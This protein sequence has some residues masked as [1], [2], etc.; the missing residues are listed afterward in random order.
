[1]MARRLCTRGLPGVIARTAGPALPQGYQPAQSSGG[2][3]P[4][5]DISQ[6]ISAAAAIQ[7]QPASEPSQN[8]GSS[9][10]ADV[11]SP[12]TGP[13]SEAHFGAAHSPLFE[14]IHNGG[15]SN[16]YA[17]KNGK[18]VDPS[19]YSSVWAGHANHVHVAAGPNTVVAL[20]K[21]AQQMGLK[22]G[23]NPYFTGHP[24][25]GGH[26]SNSY[27]YR[28]GKTKSGKVAGEAIDVSGD[29]KTMNLYA[30]R[31]ESL[32]GLG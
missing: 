2:P 17:V 22:V 1:M 3:Q 14:L 25:T 19:V 27:H 11:G 31:V 29:A 16:A 21:L 32:Y 13:G 15:G 30:K 9:P 12:N 6:L 4:A 20:G 8:G 24:E 28:T 10:S 18:K 7:G 5:P 23:S 26:V